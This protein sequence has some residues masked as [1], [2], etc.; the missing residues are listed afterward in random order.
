MW[1]TPAT[2]P[3][4]RVTP[5][6]RVTTLAGNGSPGDADGVGDAARFNGPIGVA[7]DASGRV[8]VADSY[9]DRIRAIAPDGTVTTIA[10]GPEPGLLDRPGLEAR[11]DTPCGVAVDS[12]GNILVADTGNDVIRVITPTGDVSSRIP[13]IDHWLA[14]PTGIASGADGEIYRHRRAWPR[15]GRTRPWRVA[16]RG[17]LDAWICRRRRRGRTLSPAVGRRRR[18]PGPARRRRQR[19]CFAAAGLARS[20]GAVQL[21]GPPLIA[22]RFDPD[23]F[24]QIGAAL[25]GRA[26]RRPARDRRDAR[27][28]ARWRR[29]ASGFTPASTCASTKVRR[30]ARSALESSRRRSPPAISGR[31]TSRFASARSPTSTCASA[32]RGAARSSIRPSSWRP[33]T[34]PV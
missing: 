10:G 5:D 32:A 9:N 1:P 23:D 27:R 30:F 28:G 34:R 6:G 8:I 11:F 26:A 16:R 4:R 20:H 22:P 33:P 12:S 17:R 2:M 29:A 18:Q 15:R 3:I 7:V 25:A 24:A 19:Q 14:H 13:T 31:S 21:P